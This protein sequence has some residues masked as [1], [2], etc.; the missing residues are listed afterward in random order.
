[1]TK[2][3]KFD[4]ATLKALRAEMEAVLDKYGTKSGLDISVGSMRFSD[5]EVT[6]KVEAKIKGA[7]SRSTQLVE[8]MAKAR[9]LVMKNKHGD[10]LTSY[11][12]RAHKM[13]FVYK[14]ASTGKMFK[15]SAE[16]A[17]MRFAA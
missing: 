8:T 1:M 11:N 6:I 10:V 2:I 13:P 3:A 17:E 9:G 5:A 12:T 16:S 14:C 7:V 15:C 4:K